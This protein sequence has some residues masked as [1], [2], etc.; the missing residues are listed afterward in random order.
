M[1][2][3]YAVKLAGT[4]PAMFPASCHEYFVRANGCAFSRKYQH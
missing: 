4:P 3:L 2:V 1:Y